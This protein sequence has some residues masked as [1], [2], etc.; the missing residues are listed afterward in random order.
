MYLD[1]NT[2]R[3]KQVEFIQTLDKPFNLTLKYKIKAMNV[4]CVIQIRIM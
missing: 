2:H 4:I 1:K 3:K